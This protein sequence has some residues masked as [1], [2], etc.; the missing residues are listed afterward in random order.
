[1]DW[2]FDK[3]ET[4]ETFLVTKV[5]DVKNRRTDLP[6][7]LLRG[8]SENHVLE[9]RL[10][11]T[12]S[13]RLDGR[14][15][16][17]PTKKALG[18]IA[19]LAI[20]GQTSRANLARLFWG[21]MTEANARRNLRQELY[22]ISNTPLNLAISQ[23]AESVRPS[24][25]LT[26][27]VARFQEALKAQRFAQALS[28]HD[29]PLLEHLR[30]PGA[31]GFER[32]LERERVTLAELRREALERHADELAQAGALRE[33]LA[34]YQECLRDDQLQEHHHRE[35]MRL[36]AALGERGT[37]LEQFER[38]RRVLRRE[39]GLEPLPE[40]VALAEEIR[41]GEIGAGQIPRAPVTPDAERV[42]LSEAEAIP[43]VGRESETAR[44]EAASRRGVALISGEPGIGKSRLALEFIRT[45]APGVVLRGL[46]AS[47]GTPFV[48]IA[49]AIR[50][51]LR[52][53]ETFDGLEPVW[54]REVAR[55]VPELEL[56]AAL[57][58]T[59]PT[60]EG[61]S[62][63]LEGVMRAVQR[64]VGPGG[65]LVLDDLHWFDTSSLEVIS[66]LVK[67]QNTVLNGVR[68][69]LKNAVLD[70]VPE[71]MR[72]LATAR[73]AELLERQDVIQLIESLERESR[74]ERIALERLTQSDLR[75]LAEAVTHNTVTQPFAAR[76]HQITSG[77]PLY[78]VETLRG[79]IESD[80]PVSLELPIAETVRGAVLTRVDRL[81]PA[82][83]RVL[84]AASL[85]GDG[86]RLE[87]VA[88][89]SA[90][91]DWEA[92]NALERA[93]LA[94]LLE[95]AREGHR[96][97]HDLVRQ[98]LEDGLTDARRRL[99]HRKLAE[100]L[101]AQEAVPEQI[102]DHLER[103][104]LP[105]R[106]VPFR[107]RAAEATSAVFAYRE[108]L[109]Q[110]ERAIQDGADARAVF[111]IRRARI[112]LFE[113]LDD[114]AGWAAELTAL[115]AMAETLREPALRAETMLAQA[116]FELVVGGYERTIHLTRTALEGFDL[117]DAQAAHA[118]FREGTALFRLGRLNQAEERLHSA[119]IQVP[120][121]DLVRIGELHMALSRC[122]I[123]LGDMIAA[124]THN[125]EGSHAYRQ[126]KDAH[127]EVLA[128]N[129]RGWI[130]H[131]R[132]QADVALE[133]LLESLERSRELGLVRVQRGIIVNLSAVLLHRGQ[134]ERAIPYLEEG[135]RLAREPQ[136]PRLEAMLHTHLGHADE[137]RGDLGGFERHFH[138][139][140]TIF[141]RAGA[142]AHAAQARLNRVHFLLVCGDPRSARPLLETARRAIEAT[143]LRKH[144]A[145]L[146]GLQVRSDMALGL[147]VRTAKLESA[148]AA[149]SHRELCALLDLAATKLALGDAAE[150]LEIAVGIE[151]PPPEH[152]EA[153]GLQLRAQLA[154]RHRSETLLEE[155][156]RL[157]DAANVPPLNKL[158]LYRAILATLQTSRDFERTEALHQD[159]LKLM[160]RLADTLELELRQRFL[161]YWTVLLGFSSMLEP[162]G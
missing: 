30:F 29:A 7:A 142:T 133:C 78:T 32:W 60:P 153:V 36:L 120:E 162:V 72:I 9:A 106:A 135:L 118:L 41:A 99:L 132:G 141:D 131:L 3:P 148:L 86:I 48:P 59:P 154:L 52:A 85:I 53:G 161:E 146:E 157:L 56:D 119:L 126:A 44:L 16:V 75:V 117:T 98:A 156:L 27:D 58:A 115:E 79:L 34:A 25:A 14:E 19:Y 87:L 35:I 57:S 11:G 92:L 109:E 54:R 89:A 145:W 136:E 95:P 71:Q 46:E 100:T 110:Y 80:Q 13:L 103:A 55:L 37:A 151:A 112:S 17:V 97:S 128:Q 62:R 116:D 134:L 122:M 144:Q 139:A 138:E 96:F 28:L 6:S 137:R 140:I 61:R 113:H 50:Q 143:N 155:A 69:E 10:F 66:H 105:R 160:T 83:R 114:R 73:D 90:L 5:A 68:T 104:G 38:L 67:R 70:G 26:T 45:H 149:S 152:A 15:I 129:M 64:L 147:P 43:F 93:S 150:A 123:D 84:E 1:M 125:L 20:E 102:A 121:H 107:V 63:F 4:K 12:P 2:R 33:A 159:A 31:S 18:L 82:A 40:T 42:T 24:A 8:G 88:G 77:N 49:E 130:A 101:E 51:A 158:S 23:D 21:G 81:G 39:V 65:T 108:A 124:Q 91:S 74:L 111:E 76:L 47:V 22:R 127:G 94:R